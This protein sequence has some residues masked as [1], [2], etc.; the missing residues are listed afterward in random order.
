MIL[1]NLRFED[2]DR[3]E[4]YFHI[5]NFFYFLKRLNEDQRPMAAKRIVLE[6]QTAVKEA[7]KNFYG[8]TFDE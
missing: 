4:N 1:H 5:F 8:A 2:N 7:F 3:R 6:K